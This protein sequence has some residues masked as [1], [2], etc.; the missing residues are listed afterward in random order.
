MDNPAGKMKCFH[1]QTI[2]D[3]VVACGRCYACK[4]NR[5]NGWV[6]RLER[7]SRHAQSAVFVTLTYA[8]GQCSTIKSEKPEGNNYDQLTLNYKHIQHYFKTLRNLTNADYKKRY[9]QWQKDTRKIGRNAIKP[10]RPEKF[11]YYVAGEYGSK[12]KTSPRPHYHI[13]L[14]NA[15]I[16]CIPLAW[17]I[18]DKA[19]RI[20]RGNVHQGTITGGA[21]RYT[22]KYISKPSRLP[23]F[24]GDRRT[25]EFS[26]MSKGIGKN[27]ITKQIIAW[28]KAD[29]LNRYYVP[30]AGGVQTTMPR[31]YAEKI[32]TLAERMEIAEHLERQ[33]SENFYR[34]ILANESI[35]HTVYLIHKNQEAKAFL[36]KQYTL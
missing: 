3:N 34:A 29:I 23:L 17:S 22:L 8:E 30:N 14:F 26:H 13:I 31:Y 19:R 15:N 27:Y 6:C 2:N 35:I 11:S 10:E 32:Y 20:S 5:V 36:Q 16:K 28:H 21:I 9:R 25:P 33:Q 7:H 1:P 18:G 4:K 24:Q 12:N